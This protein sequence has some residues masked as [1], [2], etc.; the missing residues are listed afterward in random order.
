MKR[1]AYFLFLFVLSQQLLAQ[2]PSRFNYQAVL[3]DPA[4]NIMEAQNVAVTINLLEGGIDG[5]QV[6]TE[7]HNTTTNDFGMVNL[8]IGSISSLAAIEW[9]SNEYF[10]QVIVNGTLMGTTQLL[11]VPYALYAGSARETQTLSDVLELDNSANGQIKNLMD[12]TDEQDAV[13]KKYSDAQFEELLIRVET[14]EAIVL[15]EDKGFA[16]LKIPSSEIVWTASTYL[17]RTSNRFEITTDLID[18][19]VIDNGVVLGYLLLFGNAWYPIPFT[20][21]NADGTNRQE[22]VFSYNLNKIIIYAYQ[23]TG[24][25]TPAVTEFRFVIIPGKENGELESIKKSI[26]LKLEIE[27]TGI[28]IKSQNQ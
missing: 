19:D 28:N 23:T 24:V 14:L 5:T 9:N 26:E 1:L 17:G 7:T 22:I 4:G 6:F 12:P 16:V 21:E 10:I 20:W 18:Q 15:Q 27:E 8:M 3:R 2:A 11:S 25:L 13:N